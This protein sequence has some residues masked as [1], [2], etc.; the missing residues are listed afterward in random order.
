MSGIDVLVGVLVGLAVGAV[1]VWLLL[2][3]QISSLES[4]KTTVEYEV[5]NLREEM[6]KLSANEAAA[7]ARAERIP[8]LE[9]ELRAKEKAS[10][11]FRSE[12]EQ[13]RVKFERIEGEMASDKRSFEER[14][15]ELESTLKQAEETLTTAFKSLASEAL[16]TS[17][18]Q[19]LE[20][21]KETLEKYQE[22]A[23]GDLDKKQVA[24]DNVVKPLTESLQKYEQ[25]LQRLEKD[26]SERDH[27]T[28][29]Q[30][31]QLVKGVQIQQSTMSDLKGLFRGPTSRGRVGEIFLKRMLEAAGLEEGLHYEMQLSETTEIGR[32]RPDCIVKMPNSK[33]LII[34]CKTPLNAYEDSLA[35][36]DDGARQIKLKEHATN[37][38][39]EVDSLAKRSYTDLS[40]DADL[41]VMYLPIEASLSAALQIDPEITS[42]GWDRR[43][44]VTTPTLLYALLQIVALDWRQESIRKNAAEITKLGKDVVD[45]IRIVA[46]H[47]RRVGASLKVANDSYNK[48]VS[49]LDRNLLT[50]AKTFQKLGTGRDA[51]IE[52]VPEVPSL[53]EEFRKPELLTLPSPDRIAELNL[54]AQIEELN[55]SELAETEVV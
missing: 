33:G 22:Q 44:V 42:Y 13:L 48:A 28:A 52:P 46:D 39:R 18:K 12:L 7:E 34:D 53:V 1:S 24:I 27:K 26:Q 21:A 41:V 35:L 55:D 2:R 43:V 6:A 30:I 4:E 10:E 50:T 47:F 37:V 8:D 9:S 3:G 15:A 16:G 11:G 25:N 14:K 5:R 51:R 40:I 17:N 49:S 29:E 32:Q 45:R 54:F 31:Q 23:K 20:L 19:F 36:D 38:R